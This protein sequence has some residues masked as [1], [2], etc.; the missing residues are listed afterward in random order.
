[1]LC[2]I[3]SHANVWNYFSDNIMGAWSVFVFFF[4]S[5]LFIKQDNKEILNYSRFFKLFIPYLLWSLIGTLIC[6]KFNFHAIYTNIPA[7]FGC[8]IFDTFPAYGILWFLREL[9]LLSLV[10]PLLSKLNDVALLFLIIIFQVLGAVP[11]L[12]YHTILNDIP[13]LF[14]AQGAYGVSWFLLGTFC[15]RKKRIIHLYKW[16]YEHLA[17]I[18]L[19]TLGIVLCAAV[20]KHA[21]QNAGAGQDAVLMFLSIQNIFMVIFPIVCAIACTRLFPETAHKVSS[22]APSIFFVYVFHPIGLMLFYHSIPASIENTVFHSILKSFEPVLV[23][24]V[25]VFAFN[26]LRRF[27]TVGKWICLST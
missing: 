2:I 6:L 19:L 3:A 20:G 18:S 27:K 8:N 1:M 7:V 24:A 15:A 9:L 21:M 17:L 25:S 14:K 26:I 16:I 13:F 10:S 22:L 4:I 23:F 12:I 11:E 5:A